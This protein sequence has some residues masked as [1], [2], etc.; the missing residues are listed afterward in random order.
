MRLC[1]GDCLDRILV[2]HKQ[3][4]LVWGFFGVVLLRFV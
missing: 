3:D 1:L 4:E 2:K